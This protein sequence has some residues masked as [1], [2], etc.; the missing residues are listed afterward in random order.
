ME[1]LPMLSSVDIE[2]KLHACMVALLVI[3]TSC[4]M[5]RLVNRQYHEEGFTRT[6]PMRNHGNSMRS[7]KFSG[8]MA[9]PILTLPGCGMTLVFRSCRSWT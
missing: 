1:E 8:E 6:R 5:M 7:S 4:S 2:A 3:L 9:E